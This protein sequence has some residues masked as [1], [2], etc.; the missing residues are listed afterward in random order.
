MTSKPSSRP[1]QETVEY[2]TP[3]S[4][5]GDP[6]FAIFKLVATVAI[7]GHPPSNKLPSGE[8]CFREL[9]SGSAES[10][11]PLSPFSGYAGAIFPASFSGHKATYEP[12]TSGFAASALRSK[13]VKGPIKDPKA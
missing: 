3:F 11:S 10:L 2:A 13:H 8:P 12:V 7:I 9:P 6:S 5:M 4:G 1:S